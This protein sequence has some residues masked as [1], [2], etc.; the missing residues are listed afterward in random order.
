MW[1]FFLSPF[2]LS[3]FLLSFLPSFSLTLKFPYFNLTEQDICPVNI[4]KLVAASR[5]PGPRGGG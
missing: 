2:L 1:F 4:T 5:D 3:S